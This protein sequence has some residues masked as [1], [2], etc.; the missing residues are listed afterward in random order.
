MKWV[1]TI[2]AMENY[3]E[4]PG[5][6]IIPGIRSNNHKIISISGVDI[7]YILTIVFLYL[8]NY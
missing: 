8:T 3:T 7:D 2:I 5:L 6:G 4:V 1:K